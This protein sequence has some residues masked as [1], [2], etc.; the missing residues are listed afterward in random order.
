MVAWRPPGLGTVTPE[1]AKARISG[2][3]GSLAGALDLQA[4][5]PEGAALQAHGACSQVGSV[6]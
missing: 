3:P 1:G 6:T 2:E 5:P 4:A